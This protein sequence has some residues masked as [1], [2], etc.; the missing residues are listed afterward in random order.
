MIFAD[1]S[2]FIALAREKDRWHKDALKLA[3]KINDP[4]LVSDLIISE[5]VTMVG[6]LEGGKAGKLLYEYFIDNC[7]IE[8]IDSEMLAKGMETFLK[9]DGSI[10]LADAVSVEIMKENRI[11]KII[12]FD[13]DF[14][15]VR[16]IERLH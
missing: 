4:L 13:G 9:Y 12:S 7:K 6:S 14:D 10:S 5:S 15:K 16:E 2:Y 11:K 1:S 8:F 3:E